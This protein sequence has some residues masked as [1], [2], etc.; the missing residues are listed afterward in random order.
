MREQGD[1][2]S[3]GEFNRV[4]KNDKDGIQEEDSYKE[5][6]QRNVKHEKSMIK[7]KK[8]PSSS[9]E[10]GSTRMTLSLKRK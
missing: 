5:V 10:T 6:T 7:D 9:L 2:L 1:Y 4:N 3:H 8:A